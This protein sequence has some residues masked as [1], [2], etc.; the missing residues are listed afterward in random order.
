MIQGLKLKF[1]STPLHQMIHQT[2]LDSKKAQVLSKK[3]NKL[4]QKR[5]IVPTIEDETGFVSTVFV[6]RRAGGQWCP[7]INIKSLNHFVI[8]PH[9]KMESIKTVKYRIRKDDWLTKLN[10]K[11]L[12]SCCFKERLYTALWCFLLSFIS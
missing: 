10:L 7:L 2:Q 1:V 6:V 11:D 9:F 8:V 12:R 5:T 4:F 3:V